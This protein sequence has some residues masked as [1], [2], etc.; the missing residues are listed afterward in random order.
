[1]D[2]GRHR[3]GPLGEVQI[4]RER[5]R[6]AQRPDPQSESELSCE[7]VA[8]WRGAGEVFGDDA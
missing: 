1:M 6:I 3:G 4:A 8:K 2:F 5:E 7:S